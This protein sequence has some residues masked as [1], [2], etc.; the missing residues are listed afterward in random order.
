M[1]AMSSAK[2][3]SAA[4]A[5][6]A[7]GTRAAE[8]AIAQI[9]TMSGRRRDSLMV[10]PCRLRRANEG[11]NVGDRGQQICYVNAEIERRG[12]LLAG[13][14]VEPSNNLS[15]RPRPPTILR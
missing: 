13:P 15:R 14:Q 4:L 12:Q 1:G 2:V 6:S 9:P 7:R 5:P 8:T 3:G 10:T 11:A